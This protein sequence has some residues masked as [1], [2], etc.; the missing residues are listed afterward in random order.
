VPG[1]AALTNL[2]QLDLLVP[3]LASRAAWLSLAPLTRLRGLSVEVAACAPGCTFLAADL[4]AALQPLQGLTGLLLRGHRSLSD[5]CGLRHGASSGG[6]RGGEDL[7]PGR[8]IP[9]AVAGE[10][11]G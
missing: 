11:P 1:L 2:Q 6:R 7:L 3:R 8:C 9:T 10:L 5:R 4:L